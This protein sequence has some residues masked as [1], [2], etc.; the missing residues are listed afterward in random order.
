MTRPLA[1]LLLS[2][3]AALAALPAPAG[4]DAC[5]PARRHDDILIL[6]VFQLALPA[7]PVTS[8]PAPAPQGVAPAAPA[9]QPVPVTAPPAGDL[10]PL[11]RAA[12]APTAAPAAAG[13]RPH[14]AVY[15]ASCLECHQQGKKAAGG[16]VI[17]DAAG[18]FAPNRPEGVLI[19]AV[20]EGRM[21]DR[22]P[23]GAAEKARFYALLAGR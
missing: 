18:R 23:F 8:P 12:S 4:A 3:A 17:F 9:P 1:C 10:P 6:T 7:P 11:L 22:R 5:A 15:R 14:V 16:V 2:G 19:D 20:A 13:E 21:P